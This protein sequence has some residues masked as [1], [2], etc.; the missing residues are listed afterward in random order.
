MAIKKGW[1]GPL[2]QST[3]GKRP[4]VC[5]YTHP[6][7][8]KKARIKIAEAGANK[9]DRER[10]YHDFERS[11]LDGRLL[12]RENATVNDALDVYLKWC[13]QRLAI[14]DRMEHGTLMRI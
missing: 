4:W 12:T 9:K 10:L 2:K 1:I 6:L 14:K 11:L 5:D 7:T 3:K 13:E 8:G